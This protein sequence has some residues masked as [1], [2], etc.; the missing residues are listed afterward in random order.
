MDSNITKSNKCQY[1]IYNYSIKEK[2]LKETFVKNLILI[3]DSKY[4]II[5]II[6]SY[7]INMII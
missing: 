5:Q 7:I 3:L 6:H 1:Q 4:N 2:I